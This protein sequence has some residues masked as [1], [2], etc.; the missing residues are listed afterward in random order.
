MASGTS[1]AVIV[2]P[3]AMHASRSSFTIDRVKG[4]GRQ[5][6][7]FQSWLGQYQYQGLMS[8]VFAIGEAITNPRSVAVDAVTHELKASDIGVD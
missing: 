2:A 8:K 7:V 5:W 1:G 3:L 4:P 6:L